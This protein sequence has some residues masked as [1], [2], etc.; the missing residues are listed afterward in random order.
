MAEPLF[1]RK[2]IIFLLP[3]IL[4]TISAKFVIFLFRNIVD[5]KSLWRWLEHK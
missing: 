2:G 5:G 1:T 3:C 4:V